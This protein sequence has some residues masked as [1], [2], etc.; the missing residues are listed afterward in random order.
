MTT[1]RA[2]RRRSR[3]SSGWPPSTRSTSSSA[4]YSTGINVATAPIIAKYGYPQVATS[5]A[6]DNVARIRQALAEF[7]LDAR[8]FQA[9]YAEGVVEAL[10]KLRRLPAAIGKRVA[11]VNVADAFG[12]ELAAAGKPA[13][14]KA[15][16]EIVYEASYPLGTQD[17]APIDQRGQ[18]GESGCVRCL[19][20]SAGHLRADRTGADSEVSTSAPSTSASAPPSRLLVRVSRTAPMA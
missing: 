3:T 16:F 15:G 19:L 1:R 4:P 8:H 11:V 10:K 14:Q 20:L 6:T 7:V 12:L 9:D 13:L 18:G 2:A 17:V 5:A